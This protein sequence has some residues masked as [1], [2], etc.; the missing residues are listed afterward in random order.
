MKE[1]RLS[2]SEKVTAG[3]WIQVY[4]LLATISRSKQ[5]LLHNWVVG[6]YVPK[7]RQAP[8]SWSSSLKLKISAH[9]IWV[10]LAAYCNV[11][12]LLKKGGYLPP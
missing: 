2:T 3:I 7:E 1:V 6:I 12:T 4:L 11:L 10:E 9:T 5:L 8:N